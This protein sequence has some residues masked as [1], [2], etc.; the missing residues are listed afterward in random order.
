MTVHGNTRFT[1]EDR[2]K[3][4]R[5]YV[6][7]GSN[8]EQIA[9]I[10]GCSERTVQ[11]WIRDLGWKD[12][13]SA[14]VEVHG[15]P[16]EELEERALRKLLG[17]LEREASE[18]QPAELLSLLTHVNRFKALIAKQ[19]GYRLMDAALV[20]GEDF[21]SFVLREFPNEATRLLEAWKAFLDEVNRRTA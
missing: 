5:L 3:A 20:V 17:R 18:L 21:Q 16:L 4:R 14:W 7:E 1:A 12:A 13:R 2:V 8:V 6:E 9:A 10:I 15:I 19:Q 11:S